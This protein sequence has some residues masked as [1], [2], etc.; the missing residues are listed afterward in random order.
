M[1]KQEKHINPLVAFQIVQKDFQDLC[2][3]M[4]VFDVF[5]SNNINPELFDKLDEFEKLLYGEYTKQFNL[6]K[7]IFKEYEESIK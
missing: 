1:K 4:D 5:K 6:A 3:L 2:N 7:K